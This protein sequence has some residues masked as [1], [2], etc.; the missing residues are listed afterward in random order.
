MLRGSGSLPCRPCWQHKQSRSTST[1]GLTIVGALLLVMMIAPAVA[2]VACILVRAPRVVEGL[3]L[4]ASL[5]VCTAAIPMTILSAGGPYYYLSE[6]IVIDITG[7]W[8]ILCTAIV[9]L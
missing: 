6:Y 2:A 5:I 1:S 4:V 9:Y 8:V 3:N 7:A